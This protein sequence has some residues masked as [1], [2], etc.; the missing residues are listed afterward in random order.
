M[1]KR[2]GNLRTK[3]KSKEIYLTNFVKTKKSV[4]L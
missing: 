3:E 1:S 4:I 2:K